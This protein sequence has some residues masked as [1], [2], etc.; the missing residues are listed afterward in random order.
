[1]K[2]G[3]TRTPTKVRQLWITLSVALF[4]VALFFFFM[5]T[6]K[7]ATT[8][9]TPP[10]PLARVSTSTETTSASTTIIAF[11]DSITAGLGLALSEAYP[12]QLERLLLQ[13]GYHVKV[14]NAGVSGETTAGGVRRA[15][16]IASQ[17]PDITLIALGG[18]DVLRGIS[19]TTTK[20]NLDEIIAILKSSGSRV[21]LIG[22]YAPEN[23]GVNYT[24]ESDA[25]YLSLAQKWKIPLVPFL[26][27]GVALNPSLNQ[28]DGIHPN[29]LGARVV[30]Q[31]NILPAII[32]LLKK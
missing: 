3:L 10:K 14:I 32:L 1:M 17:K 18:N 25:I 24:R 29:I 12:A 7:T 22:M 21:V 4:T 5:Q 26:L 9:Q 6:T 31:Q 30:A 11:G 27:K 8:S 2:E 23:L 15:Q 20:Q 16:F 13:R 19:P 28:S